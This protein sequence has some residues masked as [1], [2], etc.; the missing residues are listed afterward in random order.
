MKLSLDI[1]KRNLQSLEELKEEIT[2]LQ[3]YE[4]GKV[5]RSTLDNVGLSGFLNLIDLKNQLKSRG[6]KLIYD[7]TISY[8]ELINK[9]IELNHVEKSSKIFSRKTETQFNEIWN[10]FKLL[11]RYKNG[12]NQCHAPAIYNCETLIY[13][14]LVQNNIEVCGDY[15][16]SNRFLWS[17]VLTK[18]KFYSRELNKTKDFIELFIEYSRQSNLDLRKCNVKSLTNEL[19]L[20]LRDLMFIEEGLQVKCIVPTNGFTIDN[21]Y[22]V[23]GSKVNYQG[24]LEILLESDNHQTFYVPYSNFEEVSRKRDDILSQIGL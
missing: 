12:S 6:M 17:E 5:H 23:K 7:E 4:D 16:F 3:D 9:F 11:K 15:I 21:L 24:F 13:N 14:Y 2:L 1:A 20:K 18:P 8:K 19:H 10:N 22:F